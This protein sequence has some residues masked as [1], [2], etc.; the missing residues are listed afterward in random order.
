MGKKQYT[1][2]IYMM[3]REKQGIMNYIVGELM[4]SMIIVTSNALIYYM[5]EERVQRGCR[6]GVEMVRIW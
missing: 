4:M 5:G 6:D 2:Y 1:I 3:I